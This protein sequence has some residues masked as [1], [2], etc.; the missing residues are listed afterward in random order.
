M[1]AFPETARPPTRDRQPK[2]QQAGGR[3]VRVP[4]IS[5]EGSTTACSCGGWAKTHPR[6]KVREDAADRHLDRKHGGRGLWL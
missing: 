5:T 3:T 6:Q 1:T 2:V 4:V